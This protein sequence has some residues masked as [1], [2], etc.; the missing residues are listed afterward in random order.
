MQTDFVEAPHLD[1]LSQTLFA[2][3]NVKRLSILRQLKDHEMNVGTLA[4]RVDLSQSALSQHL[5]RLKELGIVEARRDK[6]MRFYRLS[7]NAVTAALLP[8]VS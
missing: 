7:N 8:F 4:E 6:Q 2:L 3:A 5:I 1:D